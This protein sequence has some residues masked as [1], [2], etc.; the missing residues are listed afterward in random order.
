MLDR[1][2]GDVAQSL[3]P[4]FEEALIFP[5]TFITFVSWGITDLDIDVHTNG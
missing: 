3:M 5:L 4:P 2:H 1:V